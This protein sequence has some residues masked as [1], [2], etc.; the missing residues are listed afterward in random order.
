MAIE[1]Y[2]FFFIILLCSFPV[3]LLLNFA[4]KSRS[5]WL[6]E[7]N[8][9]LTMIYILL[10]TFFLIAL[11]YPINFSFKQLIM[12]LSEGHL[13]F[14]IQTIFYIFCFLS[15]FIIPYGYYHTYRIIKNNSLFFSFG[16]IM[17][18]LA[19]LFFYFPLLLLFSSIVAS[20]FAFIF[21]FQPYLNRYTLTIPLL[22]FTF[23]RLT[24]LGLYTYIFKVY[25]T[26]F[27]IISLNK[28]KFFVRAYVTFS[29]AYIF[30][31]KIF[32]L[33][34][35]SGILNTLTT[36]NY[37]LLLLMMFLS[38]LFWI[39]RLVILYIT[40]IINS[41]QYRNLFLDNLLLIEGG[42]VE[43]PSQPSQPSSQSSSQPSS[44]V[45]TSYSLFSL[46]RHYV[47]QTFHYSRP[48]YI[49]NGNMIIG[50]CT[51]GLGCFAG[52]VAYN[53]MLETARGNELTSKANELTRQAHE[54][55]R[56]TNELTRETNE[57][58]RQATGELARQ[59][60]ELARQN[61]L[62]E[63]TGNIISVDEYKSRRIKH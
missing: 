37:F 36:F 30:F 16:L 52:Y 63:L 27:F 3:L 2:K 59:N 51:L 12:F 4:L 31:T 8:Y 1:I 13:G 44:S 46:N 45:K 57:V 7:P 33:F 55:T 40:I 20:T 21:S 62:G 53:A 47:R 24:K 35:L 15:S 14:L 5:N 58:N 6:L 22:T 48:R 49:Y 39:L 32:F 29:I 50:V 26:I 23:S 10:L 34:Y 43:Q 41:I 54:L 60:D 61:D 25:S 18:S 42:F 17:L 19:T 9:Y 28:F 11:K 38:S 56:E